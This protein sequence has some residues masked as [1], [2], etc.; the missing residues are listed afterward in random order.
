MVALT[1]ASGIV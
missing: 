1:T